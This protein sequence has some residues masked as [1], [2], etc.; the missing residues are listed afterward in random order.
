MAML[1]RS[2]KRVSP[3]RLSSLLRSE[4]DPSLALQLFKS[5]NPSPET[6]PFRYSLLS[7]DLIVT[8]LGRAKMFD[9][10]EQVLA[11]L[12]RE[13]RFSVPEALFCQVISF[14][15]RVRL[16]DRALRTYRSIPTFRCRRSV[17]SLNSVLHALL[18]CREYDR[19]D[20]VLNEFRDSASP[21]ACT[22]N[23]LIKALCGSGRLEDARE[24]L[25][26]MPQRGIRPDEVTFLTLINGLCLNSMLEEAF[27]LKDDMVR[28]HGIRPDARLYASLIKGTCKV[29]D[30]NMAFGLKEEMLRERIKV[31]AAIY[32]T[33]IHALFE[34]GMTG[35]VS[36]LLEEM[37]ENGCKPDTVTY[38][39][40]ISGSC[41]KKDFDKAYRLLHA[42]AENG[43]KPDVTSYNVIMGE[44]RKEG[45]LDEAADLFE[46]MPRRGCTPDV[47]SHRILFSGLC[48]KMQLKE[49]AFLLDEMVFK[50]YTPHDAS[51]YKLVDL[52]CQE[53]NHELLLTV[54]NS[55]RKGKAVKADYWTR[56][57]SL[58]CKNNEFSSVK[59]VD[60]L[61]TP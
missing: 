53:G 32:S 49:A 9:E 36:K 43:C 35:E 25:D 42:M 44:L 5:L 19:M 38:N 10:M 57:I 40:L 21:D 47:V 50:G 16:F 60:H 23:I 7:Y 52:L 20:E 37:R 1:G 41:K 3:F 51:I 2:A 45:K 4:K 48:E 15:A 18:K 17:K 13:T 28:V 34:V 39:V 46:D 8:K 6:K 22:C 30:V 33:L 24:V 56:M 26:E 54:S 59:L 12:G 27:K 29:G 14:Y 61:I 58:A 31:D 11:Q 55:L